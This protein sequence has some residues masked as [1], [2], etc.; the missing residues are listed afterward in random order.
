[1]EAFHDHRDAALQQRAVA[2][3]ELAFYVPLL[4]AAG[5]NSGSQSSTLVIR[6]LA[7]GDIDSK[8]WYRVLIR[9]SGQGLVLGLMLGV[10]G[11]VRVLISGH[12]MHFAALIALT[13]VA[14]VVMGCVVGALLPLLLHRL[15]IDPA[16]SSTPFIAT[17]VD[18]LGLLIYMVLAQLLLADVLARVVAE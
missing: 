2:I 6:G 16:T 15:G 11:V 14:I 12:S 13:I 9:E 7:V 10:F 4:I 18:V 8:D 1:L 17:L 3:V 5:G